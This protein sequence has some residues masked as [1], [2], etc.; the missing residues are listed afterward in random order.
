MEQQKVDMLIATNG[1]NYPEEKLP[2]IRE[3]LL[4]ADDSK[5]AMIQAVNTQDLTVMY[6]VSIFVGELGVDRF[7]LEDTKNG[8]LK[9]LLTLCCGIGL[10]WWVIDLINLPKMVK[11]Y[12]F[13]KLQ[14]YLG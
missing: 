5:W 12:N 7:M 11:E 1:K 10:I 3:Q 6:I 13:K 9:L 8:V 14:A 2:F 4:A